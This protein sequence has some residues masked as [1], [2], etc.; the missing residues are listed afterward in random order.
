MPV[1]LV[2]IHVLS[3]TFFSELKYVRHSDLLALC[4]FT[5]VIDDFHAH[6]VDEGEVSRTFQALGIFVKLMNPDTCSEFFS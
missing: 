5:V 2:L 3:K 6:T 1:L 4:L